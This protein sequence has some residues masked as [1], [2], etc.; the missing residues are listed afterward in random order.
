MDVKTQRREPVSGDMCNV[1]YTRLK[2]AFRGGGTQG[3]LK[4][5]QEIN[6][7][8]PSPHWDSKR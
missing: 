4:L 6:I 2:S 1:H 8:T 5:A 3:I 7:K